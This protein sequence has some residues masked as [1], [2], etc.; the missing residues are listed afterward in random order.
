MG[1]PDRG[2]SGSYEPALSA[3]TTDIF[4]R[5]SEVFADSAG[6]SPL[7]DHPRWRDPARFWARVEE[8]ETCWLWRGTVRADG[9]GKLWV[10]AHNVF[11][12]RVAY[13]LIYGPIPE[14]LQIDH[15]CRVRAC[16]RPSHLE[17]VTA[18]ENTRRVIPYRK[19]PDRGSYPRTEPRLSCSKGH[20]L[21]ED[22]V[23]TKKRGQRQC[24]VCSNAAKREWKKRWRA[25]QTGD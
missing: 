25:R 6:F 5:M 12:H 20:L 19:S 14:G 22:N 2:Q 21:T 16:V 7:G 11:A 9:Y 17:A 4:P 10:R 8:T 13:E 15:L 23:I 24:R 1:A 18:A 3:R